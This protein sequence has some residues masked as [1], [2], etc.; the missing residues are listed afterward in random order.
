[1]PEP[2]SGRDPVRDAPASPLEA[3]RRYDRPASSTRGSVP[4]GA[5][6]PTGTPTTAG[7]MRNPSTLPRTLGII[8]IVC[9]FVLM[10][11][12][13]ILGIVGHYLARRHGQPVTYPRT[14]WILS[15]LVTSV[16]LA[17]N[18]CAHS[19]FRLG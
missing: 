4:P 13:L 9:A 5:V 15:L 16:A 6:A 1:M 7:E 17:T 19:L 8:G 11:A 12:G 14:A 10:P 3:A 2:T 18:A